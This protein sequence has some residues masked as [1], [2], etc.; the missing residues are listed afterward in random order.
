[1][2]P[3]ARRKKAFKSK[4]VN[5]NR[6]RDDSTVKTNRVGLRNNSNQYVKRSIGKVDI[7]HKEMREPQI[8][9]GDYKIESNRNAGNR[10]YSITDEEFLQLTS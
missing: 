9:D 7:L 3:K 10:K 8:S 2:R 4:I 1:M 6:A 5:R